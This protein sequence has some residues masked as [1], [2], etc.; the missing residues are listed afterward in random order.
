VLIPTFNRRQLVLETLESLESQSVPVD[1]FEVIVAIDGSSDDTVDALKVFRPAYAFRWLYQRNQGCG[2]ASNAAARQAR[3]DVLI[4]L[5]D[6][7]IASPDLIDAHLRVQAE[8]G[9][10]L[11]Q[12]FYPLAAGYRRRGAS[13]IYE[14]SYMRSVAPTD[15]T[16]PST[17]HIWSAN[18]SVMRATFREIGGFD[19]SFREYGGEDTDFGLRVAAL[20]VPVIFEPAALSHHQHDVSYPS[21]RRQAFSAGKSLVHLAQKHAVPIDAFSGGEMTRSTDRRISVGWRRSPL[22]MEALG[23]LL[24]VALRGADVLR[25]RPLQLAIARLVH[26]YYKVGGIAVESHAAEI[27]ARHG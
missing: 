8:H 19:E 14:R 13:L 15:R 26:R 5:D 22:A 18:I 3:H 10:V 12:G 16:H 7:Q 11:V 9:P 24:T 1:R 6:D 25:V 20:G 17:A 23:R 21:V 2:A 27:E 4:F